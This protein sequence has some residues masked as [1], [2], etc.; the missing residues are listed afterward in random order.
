MH[1]HTKKMKKTIVVTLLAVSSAATLQA[2]TTITALNAVG[3]T[4]GYVEQV[5]FND[6]P[7]VASYMIGTFTST[8]GI[9]SGSIN[10]G[11]FGWT[12]FGSASFSSNAIA[13]GVFGAF[14]GAGQTAGVTGNLPT[15]VS[16][17]FVGNNIFLVIAN[18]TNDEF[19]IWDSG[20]KFAA[21]DAVLGGAPVSFATRNITLLRGQAVP[22]GNSGLGG[23]L[24][25]FNGGN[26]ITF[27]P[28]PSTALLGALGALALL[29]R[30]RN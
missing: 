10:L 21:E 19:I 20:V 3:G 7:Y 8:T 30:R 18:P 28:E 4:S 13:P 14:M 15:S 11:D 24:A 22:A 12:L 9:G 27:I 1:Q 17:P 23:P 25:T 29:R 16:G 5:R 6:A 26:A 2:A